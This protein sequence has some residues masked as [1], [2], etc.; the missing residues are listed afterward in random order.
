MNSKQKEVRIHCQ[1][2][3]VVMVVKTVYDPGKNES[4]PTSGI[5]RKLSLYLRPM[6]EFILMVSL[7]TLLGVTRQNVLSVIVLFLMALGLLELSTATE[8]T[9]WEGG[10]YWSHKKMLIIF[11]LSVRHKAQP[12]KKL[13][14]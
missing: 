4:G 12:N 5:R 8:T 6:R 3:Q 9:F 10:R 7:V 13:I 14:L 11:Q 1:G 2:Q